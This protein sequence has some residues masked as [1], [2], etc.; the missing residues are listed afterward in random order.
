MSMLEKVEIGLA[1]SIIGKILLFH[2]WSYLLEKNQTTTD[3]SDD[4]KKWLETDSNILTVKEKKIL[5]SDTEWFNDNTMD[6]ADVLN[7][8]SPV[9]SCFNV[10]LMHSHLLQFLETEELTVFPETPK[11][12]QAT[13][14]VFKVLKI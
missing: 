14:T 13:N 2:H 1:D 3:V 9:D 12:T 7:R 6:A 11:R 8:L 5:L 4:P 10:S